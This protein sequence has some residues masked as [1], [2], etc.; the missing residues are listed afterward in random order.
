M[1]VTWLMDL[2]PS[3]TLGSAALP[4]NNYLI[5][6]TLSLSDYEQEKFDKEGLIRLPLVVINNFHSYRF[7]RLSWAEFKNSLILNVVLA[8]CCCAVDRLIAKKYV[9]II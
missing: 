2:S 3:F 7:L 9:N 8:L 6:Q 4:L 5:A 1:I